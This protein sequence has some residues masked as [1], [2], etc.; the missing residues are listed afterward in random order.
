[1]PKTYLD[2]ASIFEAYKTDTTQL[3]VA[4][5][6]DTELVLFVLSQSLL[7]NSVRAFPATVEQLEVLLDNDY[8]LT[9]VL[10]DTEETYKHLTLA[11]SKWGN[12]YELVICTHGHR[13]SC[14]G[15]RS[16]TLA[17]SSSLKTII[18]RCSEQLT[19]M[20]VEAC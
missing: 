10:V 19:E 2:V 12:R 17:S 3:D 20:R 14:E 5:D 6:Y 9:H 7:Y 4:N 1:M 8:R 13:H 18:D 15:P 16:I 11:R